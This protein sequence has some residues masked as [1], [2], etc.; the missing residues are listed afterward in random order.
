M[1][2]I[3]DIQTALKVEIHFLFTP[4]DAAASVYCILFVAEAPFTFLFVFVDA[5]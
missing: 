2:R 4:F 5:V 3:D 1:G